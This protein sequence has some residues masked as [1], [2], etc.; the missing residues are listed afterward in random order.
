M[1][2]NGIYILMNRNEFKEYMTNVK[3][4][5]TFKNIQQH[6]TWKPSYK[7]FNGKNHL[8][9]MKSMGDYHIKN[10]GMSCIA[11]HVSTFPDGMICVGRPFTKTGGGF[12][13]NQNNCGITLEHVGNFDINGD[14]MTNEQKESILF[15]NAV[16]C[17]RFNILP[18]TTS[19]PYHTWVNKTK[20]CPGTNYFNGNKK[21][22]ADK[23]F[24]PLVK[25]KIIELY[26]PKPKEITFEEALKIVAD[27]IDTS[28][29]FWLKKNIKYFD[30][31]IIKVAQCE[32]HNLDKTRINLAINFDEALKLICDKAKLDFN[33]WKGQKNVDTS[34]PALIIKLGK[35]MK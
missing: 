30:K 19:L 11:Q 33:Y 25:A 20:T 17:H 32:L 14:K 13:G 3:T 26:N 21:E 9:M 8:E 1:K 4:N 6:H 34:F 22:D 31:F 28:Y 7:N 5:I 10:N 2:Q 29:D 16:L 15:V 23:Y 27:K 12:L 35:S 18:S 24:I